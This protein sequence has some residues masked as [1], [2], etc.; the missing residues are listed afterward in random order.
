MSMTKR[1][2]APHVTMR[3]RSS[4]SL[5]QITLSCAKV[6]PSPSDQ[7]ETHLHNVQPRATWRSKISIIVPR[8]NG[9]QPCC[10]T[11]LRP[12]TR[13]SIHTSYLSK[14]LPMPVHRKPSWRRCLTINR[15][16]S[17]VSAT[18]LEHN[19][20]PT[21]VKMPR[22]PNCALTSI[23]HEAHHRSSDSTAKVN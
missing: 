12:T 5:S 15:H 4:H 16:Q 9:L 6:C 11:R 14:R 20:R 10:M 13:V 21:L 18:G 1:T 17:Q 8:R 22:R 2:Q 19:Q 7:L 3:L 23:K